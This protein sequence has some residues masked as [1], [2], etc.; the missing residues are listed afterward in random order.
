M[1]Y[2]LQTRAN[3]KSYKLPSQHAI[4]HKMKVLVNKHKRR[5]QWGGK[6][7]PGLFCRRHIDNEHWTVA[8]D[9][10]DLKHT[11]KIQHHATT[12]HNPMHMQNIGTSRGLVYKGE[13]L[14]QS[15]LLNKKQSSRTVKL[16]IYLELTKPA[17]RNKWYDIIPGF[18][19]WQSDYTH[20][21]PS[22]RW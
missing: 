6:N 22:R 21:H 7:R 10:P 8:R 13:R 18:T 20:V 15:G 4:S 3:K 17:F 19:L 2:P 5:A 14:A 1:C 12:G 16:L 9:N 11:K